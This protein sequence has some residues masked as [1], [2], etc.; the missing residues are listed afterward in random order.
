MPG[1]IILDALSLVADLHVE[2]VALVVVVLLD[3]DESFRELDKFESCD[4]LRVIIHDVCLRLGS[5][6]RNGIPQ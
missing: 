6:K 5:N 4:V 2:D 3:P 1:T